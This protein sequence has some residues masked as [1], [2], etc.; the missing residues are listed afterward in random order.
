MARSHG[1]TLT[2]G[3]AEVPEYLSQAGRRRTGRKRPN[4][5]AE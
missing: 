3:I 2:D 1:D 5:G 4:T